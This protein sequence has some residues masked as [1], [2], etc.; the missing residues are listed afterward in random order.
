MATARAVISGAGTSV[1]AFGARGTPPVTNATEEWTVP[2]AVTN[3][4]ITD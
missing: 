4:T 1:A 3:T 2:Q